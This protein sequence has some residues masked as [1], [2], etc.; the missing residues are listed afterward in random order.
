MP[1][2]KLHLDALR[3]ESFATTEPVPGVRGTVH[4]RGTRPP[5]DPTP[6]VEI[7]ACTCAASCLCPTA[8]YYCATAPA[9]VVSC[10]YTA[11]VSCWYDT[12]DC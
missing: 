9:T 11:N 3:V 12:H 5:P 1:G 4:G 8:A 10:D 6:P 2:R 7:D